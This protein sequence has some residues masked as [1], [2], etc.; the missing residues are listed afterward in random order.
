MT[1]ESA[2]PACGDKVGASF[3]DLP[4]IPTNS[5]L[6]IND[7]EAALAFP[8]APLRLCLC[9]GCGFIFNAAWEA[10]RTVYSESY[11]ET[12]GF[13]PTFNAFHERL[14]RDLIARH[15][16]HGKRVIEIGCGKG[17]FLAL[18]CRLGDNEGIGYDPTFV[19]GR[20]GDATAG[21][22]R[23]LREL[24]DET[25]GPVACDFLCCKMTLEHI[26]DVGRFVG[27]VRRALDGQEGTCV[28]FQVPNAKLVLQDEAFWDVYYEHCSYFTAHSLS[29]L[30]RRCGFA[31]DRVWTDYD[32]QYLMIE[33]RP[34]SAPVPVPAGQ[35]AVAETRQ[36]AEAFRQGV[37]ATIATWREQ[38][39]EAAASGRR[40][41]LWGSGSKAVAFLTTV[42]LNGE[43]ASVV[44]INPFRHG[45]YLPATGHEIISPDELSTTPP[46]LVVVMNSVYRDEIRKMLQAQGC[47]PELQCL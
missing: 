30:F 21:R 41:V 28:F 7:R 33:A 27:M 6:L 31:V 14:A 11:E 23:F 39:T 34:A 25:T 9:P 40:T 35:A 47:A 36:W 8:V 18:L 24:F 43:V 13:S 20:L 26:P 29:G 32:G 37:G 15:D 3:Y 45:R 1:I 5:C 12:Q 19:P 22:A 4:A 42:G 16:L 46:D 17:E 38:L 10:S 2:C 44:D